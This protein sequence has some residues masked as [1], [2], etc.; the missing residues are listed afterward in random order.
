MDRTFSQDELDDFATRQR[1]HA[2]GQVARLWLYVSVGLAVLVGLFYK[3]LDPLQTCI[4]C[5]TLFNFILVFAYAS[6]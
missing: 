4:A 5:V 6:Q 2:V 3:S 1:Q